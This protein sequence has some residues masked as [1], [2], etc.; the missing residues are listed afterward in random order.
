[1]RVRSKNSTHHKKEKYSVKHYHIIEF[2]KSEFV[3]LILKEVKVYFHDKKLAL[4]LLSVQR[5]EH[6]QWAVYIYSKVKY[7]WWP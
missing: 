3:F 1:M 2:E 5:F 7:C 4:V 6:F